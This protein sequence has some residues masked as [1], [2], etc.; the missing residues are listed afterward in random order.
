MI[1]PPRKSPSTLIGPS[2]LVHAMPCEKNISVGWCGCFEENDGD[3]LDAGRAS[4]M[5]CALQQES[6]QRR[7][8]G[9]CSCAKSDVGVQKLFSVLV[10]G[11]DIFRGATHHSV[12][13]S[14][15]LALVFQGVSKYSLVE[16][17][18]CGR[19]MPYRKSV[20]WRFHK[21]RGILR[22][23][24][25]FTEALSAER[26]VHLSQAEGHSNVNGK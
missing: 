4:C 9:L 13:Q 5:R 8:R 2:K 22:T 15:R 6:R 10:R 26:S 18:A 12:P 11:E 14:T 23:H 16:H 24:S 17:P 21:R 19:K 7:E 25:I 20:G 3:N 1:P